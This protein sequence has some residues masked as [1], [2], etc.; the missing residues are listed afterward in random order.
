MPHSIT[1]GE[2]HVNHGQSTVG[3]DMDGSDIFLSAFCQSCI[4]GEKA[5]DVVEEAYCSTMLCLLGN[6]AMEEKTLISFPE[7]YKIPYMKF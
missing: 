4:T 7:E 5:K 3:V 1:R 6:K 2:V